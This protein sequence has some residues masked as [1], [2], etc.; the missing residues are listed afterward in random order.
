[1]QRLVQWF[2]RKDGGT[3][4]VEDFPVPDPQPGD[5]R[6]VQRR[7]AWRVKFAEVSMKYGGEPRKARRKMARAILKRQRQEA[8]QPERQ[9][10]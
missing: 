3:I 10:A 6:Q 9:A 2:R 7:I 8:Q 5:S 1:M 4:R